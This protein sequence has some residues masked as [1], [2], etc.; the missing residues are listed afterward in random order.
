MEQLAIVYT[1]QISKKGEIKYFQIPLPGTKKKIVAVEVS[2]FLFTEAK[3]PAP[4][5]D[6]VTPDPTPVSPANNNCPNPG[7]AS[8]DP[9]SSN[10]VNGI[11]TQ[12]F[13]IGAAVNPTFIYQCGVYSVVITVTAV[14]GD[15]PESIAAKLATEVNN[16]TLAIWNQ[17][18][19]NNRN[20]KP[21]AN[22]NGA[23]LTLTVDSQHSFF[24]SG[25]GSC[26]GAPP[27]PP[28]PPPG[29]SLLQYD[30][31]FAIKNNEKAGTL[32]LQSPDATDIFFK[33]EA[34]TEDRNIG[35]G[36]YTMSAEA[37]SEWLRG[38]K[39]L[40]SDILIQTESPILEA[41]YKDVWGDYYNKDLN[42]QLNI[43][44]WYEK[45]NL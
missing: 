45:N 22:S 13:Q 4:A 26:A 27:P 21:T 5:P 23:Q 44:I 29:P 37:G 40:A 7:S 16:T 14:D 15:T 19:S 33:Y 30:P 24:A 2:A 17:F 34:F 42:Y 8:I 3:L 38:K 31:L 9:V 28:P 36:D 1:E 35:F 43:I 12:V 41:Y 10:T 32:S 6:P 11:T 18:G 20:Y 25:Q 39:R